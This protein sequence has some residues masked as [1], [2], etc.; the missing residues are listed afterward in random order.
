MQIIT[1]NGTQ[2]AEKKL[3]KFREENGI[4][5]TSALVYHPQ[6]NGQVEVTNRTITTFLKWKVGENLGTCADLI[7]ETMW[8]YQTSIR[9]PTG[10][11]PFTLA[12]GINVVVPSELV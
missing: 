8:S 3:G 2:I 7:L 5:L 1:D 6:S 12:F 10:Y 9:T 11:T 4:K